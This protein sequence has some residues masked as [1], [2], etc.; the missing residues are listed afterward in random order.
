M[1][2]S[3]MLP[4]YIEQ[5]QPFVK[6]KKKQMDKLDTAVERKEGIG[7]WFVIIRPDKCKTILE[8]LLI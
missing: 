7:K 6:L 1:L 8:P 5:I 4:P 3:I 2:N